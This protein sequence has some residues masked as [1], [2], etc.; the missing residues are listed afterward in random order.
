[1]SLLA[2]LLVPEWNSWIG[3]AKLS[4]WK[5]F[6]VKSVVFNSKRKAPTGGY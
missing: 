2:H 1:M 5:Q 6:R 3:I 4:Q